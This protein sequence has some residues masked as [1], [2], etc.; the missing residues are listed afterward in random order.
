MYLGRNVGGTRKVTFLHLLPVRSQHLLGSE[1][2]NF[3]GLSPSWEAGSCAAFYGTRR[4]I[5]AF[6]RALHWSL[7]WTRL[8]QSIPPHP[9]SLRSILIQPTHLRLGLSS[10]LFPYGFPTDIL[11]AFLFS[12]IRAI[13][14]AHLTRLDFIILIIL[15]WKYC[16]IRYL[17]VRAASCCV[18]QNSIFVS[19]S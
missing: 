11:Y 6:T 12:P 15:G 4:F 5:T 10:G 16:N 19:V 9:I 2:T 8:V 14:P 1:N 13:C 18:S 7:S 17:Y 3:T